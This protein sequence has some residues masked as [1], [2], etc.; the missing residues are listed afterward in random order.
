M[1]V[2]IQ[3][4]TNRR[5]GAKLSYKRGPT[6]AE[7]EHEKSLAGQ[8]TNCTG[9]LDL[10]ISNTQIRISQ[11]TVII[12]PCPIEWDGNILRKGIDAFFACESGR[13]GQDSFYLFIQ[14][15]FIESFVYDKS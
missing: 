2:L 6:R 7:K 8:K 5:F 13:L 1:C 11:A 10:M 9:H 4:M 12:K 14:Q 3:A 15:I